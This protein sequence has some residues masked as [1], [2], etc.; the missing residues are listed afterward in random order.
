MT[1]IEMDQ[2]TAASS[3]GVEAKGRHLARPP[4]RKVP[5]KRELEV[6]RYVS[7]RLRRRRIM[8]GLTQ[9][10]IADLVGVTVQQ[11]H[12]YEAGINRLSAARLYQVAQAL[13]VEI[14]YFFKDLEAADGP[15]ARMPRQKMLESLA[16]NFMSFKSDKHREALCQFTRAFTHWD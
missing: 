11:A 6:D 13:R 12:K 7:M 2:A 9:Q 5:S 16:Q 1:R 8:L 3:A 14:N 10:Q 15:Q 4:V